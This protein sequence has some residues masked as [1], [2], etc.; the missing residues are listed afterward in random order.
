MR[1]SSV[2]Q[3][4]CCLFGWRRRQGSS[5]SCGASAMAASSRRDTAACSVHCCCKPP[6][7]QTDASMEVVRTR[8]A[9]DPSQ[10]AHYVARARRPCQ[11]LAG[12]PKLVCIYV[13]PRDTSSFGTARCMSRER[14]KPVKG[15]QFGPDLMALCSEEQ[16]TVTHCWHRD[17]VTRAASVRAD[18]YFTAARHCFTSDR[19]SIAL[20]VELSRLLQR[21]DCK[22]PW[23]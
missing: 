7:L 5:S 22:A 11:A 20:H 8:A 18:L 1:A 19:L 3:T 21:A 10:L 16:S 6:T 17:N 12:S 15:P 14:Q 9:I 23:S 4:T 2:A 13:S